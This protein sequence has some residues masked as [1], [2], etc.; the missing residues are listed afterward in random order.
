MFFPKQAHS[1]VLASDA[2]ADLIEGRLQYLQFSRK[3]SQEEAICAGGTHPKG[4]V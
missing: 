2:K 4:K 1:S 3:Q